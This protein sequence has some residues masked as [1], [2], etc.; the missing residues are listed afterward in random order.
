MSQREAELTIG[1]LG[2]AT[3]CFLSSAVNRTGAFAA[4]TADGLVAD[5]SF[6][7]LG[8]DVAGPA[9][10]LSNMPTSPRSTSAL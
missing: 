8:R 2:L 3:S 6:D 10:A 1:R 9:P 7:E 5:L 4:A